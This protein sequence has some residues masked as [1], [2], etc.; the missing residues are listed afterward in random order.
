M[1]LSKD[2][3]TIEGSYIDADNNFNPSVQFNSNNMQINNHLQPVQ[4]R[5]NKSQIDD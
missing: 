3:S 2:L 4:N 1:N 5:P